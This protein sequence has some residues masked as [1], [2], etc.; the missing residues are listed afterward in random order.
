MKHIINVIEKIQDGSRKYAVEV[1]GKIF[2]SIDTLHSAISY[3]NE[4]FGAVPDT[5]TI[6]NKKFNLNMIE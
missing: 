5:I 2:Y 1:D 3:V 4:Q 6:N